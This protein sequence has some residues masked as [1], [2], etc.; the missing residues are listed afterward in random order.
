MAGAGH[1]ALEEHDAA[2]E[3]ARGLL[4]GALVGVDELVRVGDH[5]D[6]APAA[7]G[8]GLEHERV[9]DVLGGGQRRLD[10]VDTAAAPRRHRDADLLGDQL[11]ADLVAELV[12]GLG[13][14]ADE[15]HPDL[16]TQFREGRILGH[17]TPTDPG[18]IGLGDTQRLLE[19]LQVEIRARR[20]GA[21]VV[22]DVGLAHEGGVAVDIGVQRDRLDR[23][24][25][26][27]GEVPD[28]VDEAYRGLTTIH[29]GN[30]AEQP[31]SSFH[32]VAEARSG[33]VAT[34][35]PG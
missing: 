28:G 14:R 34:A 16:L 3:G 31:V 10:G 7:T 26:L 19:R 29:D 22:G 32:Y 12:H 13:A 27:G 9:A 6:A 5:P 20:S 18:R 30:A 2:A 17:E 25:G 24:P 33:D 4:A 23:G 11:G 1:Q 15:G 21:Q 35:G 8:G